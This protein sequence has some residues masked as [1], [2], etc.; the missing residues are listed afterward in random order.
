MRVLDLSELVA[1]HETHAPADDR[2]GHRARLQALAPT[3]TPVMADAGA[4]RAGDHEPRGQR[5][6]RDAA[7]RHHRPS[8]PRTSTSTR[9]H[10]RRQRRIAAG[11]YVVL[12]VTDTGVGMDAETL[13]HIFEPFFTTKEMGKG[14][15]LGLATVYGIV[16]QNGGDISVYSEPGRGTHFKVYLPRAAQQLRPSRRAPTATTRAA[17]RGNETIC[18]VEDEPH[19][20]AA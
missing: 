20:F 11:P 8:R 1:T 16:K 7:R 2:R 15:G 13:A 4:D 6:R 5:A 3:P 14:T 19:R 18:V 10:D 12:A 17:L 9:R